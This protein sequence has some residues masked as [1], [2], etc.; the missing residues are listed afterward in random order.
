MFVHNSTS[1]ISEHKKTAR[2]FSCPV[3]FFVGFFFETS[4]PL[5]L[6][7][8]VS[9][10]W[11]TLIKAG[12]IKRT[13]PVPPCGTSRC[14]CWKK[15]KT[16]KFAQSILSV[17]LWGNRKTVGGGEWNSASVCGLALEVSE[18]KTITKTAADFG[19]RWEDKRDARIHIWTGGKTIMKPAVRAQTQQRDLTNKRCRFL[20]TQTACP[21]SR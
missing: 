8:T 3:F 18:S 6:E 17:P 9:L 21:G 4:N 10:F 16:K 14:S 15:R 12:E 19:G 11:Q 7:T 20:T 2:L 13:K 1:E 5:I